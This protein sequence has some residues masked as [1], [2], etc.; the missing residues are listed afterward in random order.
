MSIE[1][2]RVESARFILQGHVNRLRVDVE[3]LDGAADA[4]SRD[5]DKDRARE[6]SEIASRLSGAANLL[7]TG[8]GILAGTVGE[9]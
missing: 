9:T 3:S 8:E 2:R 7:E 1:K 5:G 4:A 6:L